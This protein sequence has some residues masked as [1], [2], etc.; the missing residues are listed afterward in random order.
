M[1]DRLV[2]QMLL[3]LR[4]AIRF[5]AL[6]PTNHPALEEIL[7]AASRSADTLARRVGGEAVF[8]LISDSLYLGRELLAHASLE[9]NGLL[10][11]MQA[12]GLDAVTFIAPV[13]RGDIGDL[14]MFVAGLAQD[15]P[16]EGTVRLNE[17]AFSISELDAEGSF[18]GLRKAYARSLDVL[19]GIAMA[20]GSEQDFDLSGATWAVEQLIEQTLAQPGAALLLSNL[21]GHDEYTF[22]HSVNVCVLSLALAR[23]SGL[24]RE[25]LTVLGVG[26]LLHDIGKVSIP[27]ATLQHPGRL[28]NNQ[29]A[30]IKTHPSE[31]AGSILAA[32]SPTQEVAAVVAF[33]HHAR[34]DQSGY[35]KVGYRKELHFF[36]RLVATTDTYDAIT[37]RRSYRRPET[38][39]RALRVLTK[40]SGSLY[41]PDFV[42]AFVT[43]MG[44]YP[45][46]SL[47]KLE[48]GEVVMVTQNREGENLPDVVL[49]Q[50]PDGALL[51]TP[52]PFSLGGKTIVDQ[53]PPE[54]VGVDPASLLEVSGFTEPE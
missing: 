28:D 40:G 24:N 50:A 54:T 15:L 32:A 11:D 53:L 33:E 8:T 13:A 34:F 26:A 10:R 49:V 20:S 5:A 21:K 23:M 38:P 27:A 12:R 14:A 39:N 19:R 2:R 1:N 51:S 25:Q 41:D 46:G 30:E 37:T 7:T 3:D 4:S 52:E 42:S 18:Q 31:G 29:W 43:M 6:Y 9:F 36:S 17:G 44:I 35:P 47:L 16:A 22:Y 45:A 48:G